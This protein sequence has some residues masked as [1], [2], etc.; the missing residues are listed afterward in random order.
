MVCD[1]PKLRWAFWGQCA[2]WQPPEVEATAV[3]EALPD[4]RADL[5][6]AYMPVLDCIAQR[7]SGGDYGA[8]NRRSSASG[9]YQW[10]RG[11]WRTAATR[12]G[13]GAWA[14]TPARLVPPEVQDYVTAVHVRDYGL[15][16]WNASNGR[17]CAGLIPR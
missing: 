16:A 5:V 10:I 1:H 4:P 15:G 7:E 2:T 3:A 11:S 13:E 8:Q 14:E 17:R 6:A 9:R 12:A